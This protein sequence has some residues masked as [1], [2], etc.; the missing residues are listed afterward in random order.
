[1]NQHLIGS[2]LQISSDTADGKNAEMQV[3]SGTSALGGLRK[4][5][6]SYKA[7]KRMTSAL[8]VDGVAKVFLGH[9]DLNSPSRGPA[10]E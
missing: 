3:L 6:V 8:G 10:I 9:R 2:L 1:M 4:V 7:N 5:E